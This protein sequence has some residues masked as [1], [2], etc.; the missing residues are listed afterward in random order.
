MAANRV[1]IVEDEPVIGLEIQESLTDLG[2][3]V[4]GTVNTSEKGIETALAEEPDLVLMDICLSGSIDGIA[5]ASVIS[6]DLQIPVI[7]LT[8]LYDNETRHRVKQVPLK[9]SDQSLENQE[10]H[11]EATQDPFCFNHEPVVSGGR[12]DLGRRSGRA[13]GLELGSDLP[14]HADP[15]GKRGPVLV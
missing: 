14:F 15:G 6:A 4:I 3:A 9:C 10:K 11:D 8:S 2:Y 1:L 7:F 12:G 13:P 5:A